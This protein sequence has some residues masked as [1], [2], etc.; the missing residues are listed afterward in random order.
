MRSDPERRYGVLVPV[1]PP[2]VA[3][4]RLAALG[5]RTR[6]ELAASFAADTVTAALACP[7][8]GSLLVVT[9]DH[10]LA[11]ALSE[12]GADAVPDG[13][14]DDLNESLVLAAAELRRRRPDLSPVVLT[15]D[16]PGL[17]PDELT[18]AL[19]EAPRNRPAFVPDAD[20]LGTTLLVAP[21]ATDL[22]PRFGPGSRQ[23]HLSAGARE[24]ALD[25]VPGLRR[26]V[27]EPDDLAEALMLGVGSRTALVATSRRL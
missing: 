14:S 5:D 1:K 9:D 2:A 27:D 19:T 4:S 3:K 16:L 8:V 11:G 7:L 22:L 15:A 25:D 12:L 18:R 13:R 24:L 10:A 6:R 21:A 20:R 17:K 23:A 26:D